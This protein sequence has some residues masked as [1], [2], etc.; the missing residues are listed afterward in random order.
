MYITYMNI[1]I[2][3][4]NHYCLLF[5]TALFL[6]SYINLNNAT[7]VHGVKKVLVRIKINYNQS[8]LTPS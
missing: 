5:K 1:T 4:I 8:Y 3:I 7:S 2:E 6:L